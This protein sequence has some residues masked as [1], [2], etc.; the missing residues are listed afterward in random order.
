MDDT[1]ARLLSND[2]RVYYV[3]RKR[4]ARQHTE[5]LSGKLINDNNRKTGRAYRSSI[6]ELHNEQYDP[7]FG[8]NW[9][10]SSVIGLLFT[11]DPGSN[12]A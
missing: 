12:A 8:S 5:A 10:T 2:T 6:S 1:I 3:L 9:C 11:V 4:C 7:T